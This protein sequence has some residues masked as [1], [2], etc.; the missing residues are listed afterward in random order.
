MCS[1]VKQGFLIALV[2]AVTLPVH[3][4][5]DEA[6]KAYLLGNFEKARYE[7]LVAATDGN[8]Q[9]Q[10]LLG[11]IYFNGDGVTKD[12]PLAMYWYEKAAD[13][14]F[15]E[16]QYRLGML[17]LEG[18]DG[19]SKDYD[20]AY[21]WLKRSVE[22]GKQSA[23]PHLE[24][25]YK[26]DTGKV[27]NLNESIEILQQVAEK[28]E[29]LARFL[30][31]QKLIKGEGITQ[32][33][34]RAI[35]ML[36]D[37]AKR[38]F[39]KAQKLLGELYYYGTGVEADYVEAYGWSMAYAGTNELGG[40]AREGKQTAR[41]ALRKLEEDRHQEAYLRSKQY[42]E[43]YVLPFHKNAREVGPDK[44]RIVVRSQKSRPWTCRISEIDFGHRNRAGRASNHER[45][46]K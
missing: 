6:T 23:E 13:N 17:F 27:V 34:P 29:K 39:V 36:T 44:Y 21:T 11:Q 30:L 37:D 16:A 24:A 12:L 33:K 7:A 46:F 22:N 28:G 26:T 4:G 41:S 15:V 19:V 31:S 3:A 14:N 8:P 5:F 10:M 1:S 9:A 38:G 42:Y 2:L 35:K 20:K 40:L 32:D 25:L 18:K 43:Q 45:Q